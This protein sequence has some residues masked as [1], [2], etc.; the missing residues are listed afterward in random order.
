M[1]GTTRPKED[2]MKLKDFVP[3]IMLRVAKRLKQGK[4]LFT[5]YDSALA[6]C[7]SGY[8][9]DDLINAVYEKTLRYREFLVRQRP[10]VSDIDS[11]RTL[12]GLGLATCNRELNVIDFGGACG[13][14]YFLAR[15]VLGNSITIRWHV[16]ETPKMASRATE[17]ADE[18][19]KFFD[20][21][22][23]AKNELNRVDLLFSSSALQYV[24]H[25]YEFLKRL[26]ECGADQMFFTKIGLS[27]LQMELITIQKS[28][29]SG[30]GP[31][32]MPEGMRDKKIQYPVTFARKDKFEEI[33]RKNYS[34][35]IQF[36]EDKGSYQAV[37]HTIDLYGYFCSKKIST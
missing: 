23:K 18:H 31:G 22:Q 17:L 5:S 10:L 27:T 34:I 21:I 8:E 32:P 16:V 4:A 6:A 14:H 35:D 15:V 12:I 33:L 37:N 26:T 7:K 28:S 25:P 20:D 19:L 3:P 13:A 36:N 29:L 24:P 2:Q 9:E 30:N 11:L 1:L